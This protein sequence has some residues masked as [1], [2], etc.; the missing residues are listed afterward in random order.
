M[1]RRTI[2]LVAF[3]AG[4]DPSGAQDFASIMDP[5]S[6]LVLFE[7]MSSPDG[8]DIEFRGVPKGLTNQKLW[9]DPEYLKTLK[10]VLE[11]Y[12]PCTYEQGSKHKRKM[13]VAGEIGV[14]FICRLVGNPS[15]AEPADWPV[16][17]EMAVEAPLQRE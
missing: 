13:G 16:N 4:A 2:C 12:L 11:G 6:G 5:A 15:R 7:L 9:L 10:I 3:L 8:G 14:E 1:I 17:E